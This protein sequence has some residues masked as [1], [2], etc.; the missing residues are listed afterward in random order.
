MSEFIELS[1]RCLAAKKTSNGVRVEEVLF[2]E[3][4]LCSL[5]ASEY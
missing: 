4:A 3:G 2:G 1:T 5:F